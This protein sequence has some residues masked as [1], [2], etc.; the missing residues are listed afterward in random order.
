MGGELTTAPFAAA[1]AE[2]VATQ[3]GRFRGHGGFVTLP[4]WADILD[5]HFPATDQ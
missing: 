2:L 4:A 3:A 1:L 5:R